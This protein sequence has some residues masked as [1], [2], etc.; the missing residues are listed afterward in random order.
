MRCWPPWGW[1]YRNGRYLLA[2]HVGTRGW[3]R[4]H[5]TVRRIQRLVW[6]V[7]GMCSVSHFEFIFIHFRLLSSMFLVISELC[8]ISELP[9]LHCFIPQHSQCIR[10]RLNNFELLLDWS[11]WFLW[12]TIRQGAY[13]ALVFITRWDPPSWTNRCPF[14]IQTPPWTGLLSPNV[15]VSGHFLVWRGV[16]D[17]HSMTLTHPSVRWPYT[18][19]LLAS[20]VAQAPMVLGTT[21]P[22]CQLVWFEGDNLRHQGWV[23]VIGSWCRFAGHRSVNSRAKGPTSENLAKPPLISI[24]PSVIF[25]LFTFPITVLTPGI[26]SNRECIPTPIKNN[27]TER[28]NSVY[29][30]EA[31]AIHSSKKLE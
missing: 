3:N 17:E 13:L 21:Q 9:H 25:A 15:R 5:Y 10:C 29:T 12:M 26:Y 22:G 1:G 18:P 4:C 20:P 31:S 27:T 7:Q 6:Y 16:E 30:Y 19:S 11:L 14:P 23:Y 2:C 8:D 24:S 28:H